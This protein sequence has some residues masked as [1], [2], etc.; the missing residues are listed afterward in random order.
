MEAHNLAFLRLTQKR[1]EKGHDNMR[2]NYS[3]QKS[4]FASG[5]RMKF[6]GKLR[7]RNQQKYLDFLQRITRF[8]I[9]S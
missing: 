7:F 3:Q 2:W 1:Y 5:H 9:G 6:T 8:Y 4:L